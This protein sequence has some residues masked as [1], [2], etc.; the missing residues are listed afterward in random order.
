MRTTAIWSYVL[1]LIGISSLPFNVLASDLA[2]LRTLTE[3][4]ARLSEFETHSRIYLAP[5][6]TG[7]SVQIISDGIR[8]AQ[9][10]EPYFR[11]PLSWR[12]IDD[13]Q[14]QLNRATGRH[15]KIH[16]VAAAVDYTHAQMRESRASTSHVLRE[17]L[18]RSLD[19]ERKA[20]HGQVAELA[21]ARERGM[22]L[23]KSTRSQTFDLTEPS[24]R[25]RS[26]QLKVLQDPAAALR[27]LQDDLKDAHPRARFGALPSSQVTELH[28]AGKLREVGRA[29]KERIFVTTSGPRITVLPMRS[30]ESAVASQ[31]YAQSG[32]VVV[33]TLRQVPHMYPAF[34]Q[35]L[36]IGAGVAAPLVAWEAYHHGSQALALFDDP[37]G[38]HTPLPYLHLGIMAGHTAEAVTL[39]WMTGSHFSVFGLHTV[40]VFGMGASQVF[41]P[42]AVTVQSLKFGTS[43]YEYYT[44]RIG[45]HEFQ[46][47]A[48]GPAY[49]VTLTGGGALVC[50]F[51]PAIGTAVCA[52]TG[53]I[54]SIPVT[55]WDRLYRQKRRAEFAEELHQFKL[56]ALRKKYERKT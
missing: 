5:A 48:M 9:G 44:G 56:D 47:R 43:L 45:L 3:Q 35:T 21:E 23:T 19:T 16:Q 28:Q 18:L 6:R 38:R 34:A 42:V 41:L 52:T 14:S 29:A 40:N 13:I 53:A 4:S 36:A 50:S 27:I 37:T 31:Q 2:A 20:F 10:S 54:I 15:W 11:R 17:K 1:G 51:I 33:S 7:D 55:I 26:L 22:V 39:A 8:R 46:D 32:R 30:F 12:E 24:Q 49:F 25:P